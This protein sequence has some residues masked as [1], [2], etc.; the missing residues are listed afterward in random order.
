MGK[1]FYAVKKGYKTGVFATWDE[2][3]KQVSGFSGAVYKSFKTELEARA[4]L[5]NESVEPKTPEQKRKTAGNAAVAYV[6]GSYLDATKEF[7]YGVVLF[8]RNM[9]LRLS[10]KFSDKDYVKMRNVAGEIKG[11][12][13]AMRYCVE[14][15][16]KELEIVYDYEGIERWCTGDWKATK[17]GTI[18]YKKFYD[19]LTDRLNVTFRKVKGHSGDTYN[20]L[21]DQLARS[22]LGL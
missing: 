3:K 6:D 18:A 11:A 7:S 4:F 22:A 16:I 9:E 20:D 10:E 12:E 19:S 2:C 21:A 8:Y 15:D 17:P 1:K 5:S 14:N 13:K